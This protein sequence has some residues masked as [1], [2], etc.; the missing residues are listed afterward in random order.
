MQIEQINL[1]EEIINTMKRLGFT[2][3]S[4][5]TLRTNQK[6]INA[7]NK[8]AGLQRTMLTMLFFDILMF[9]PKPVPTN[10]RI[11]LNVATDP[12]VWL[13]D[14]RGT[15]LPFMRVNEGEFFL[16]LN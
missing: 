6:F 9:Q 8:E 4:I 1:C 11:A 14:M 10:I 13:G 7:Y 12:V 2:D 16:T 15:V 3:T 5:E